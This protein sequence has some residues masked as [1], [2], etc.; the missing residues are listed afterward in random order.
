MWYVALVKTSFLFITLISLSGCTHNSDS[1]PP[2]KPAAPIVEP[3]S[4][5]THE[6]AE[7]EVV[8]STASYFHFEG[9]IGTPYS[10]L[11][12]DS[13]KFAADYNLQLNDVFIKDGKVFLISDL[14]NLDDTSI[15]DFIASSCV[16]RK[17][18]EKESQFTDSSLEFNSQYHFLNNE[19]HFNMAAD[20]T[21][22]AQAV[23]SAGEASSPTI[24]CHYNIVK[25]KSLNEIKKKATI[26]AVVRNNF[27]G[28]VTITTI[29]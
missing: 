3:A 10:N 22:S 16:I 8:A 26:E 5:T 25:T 4:A 23:Y 13:E 21:Y 19:T 27:G 28:L 6:T 15:P 7:P 9:S 24:L 11:D 1:S 12:K 14:Q 17:F 29:K 18:V 20:K 2:A